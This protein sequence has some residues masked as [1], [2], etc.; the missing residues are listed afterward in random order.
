MKINKKNAFLL[1]EEYFG[2]QQYA[3]DFHGNLM[4]RDGYGNPDYYI[5][6]YGKKIYCGWNIHH[7]LPVAKGGSNRKNNLICT[8]IYT[9]EMADDKTTYWIDDSLYQVQHIWGEEGYGIFKLN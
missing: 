4:C 8:N 5:F 6:Y 9:N 3:E 2:N 7:I 1:W